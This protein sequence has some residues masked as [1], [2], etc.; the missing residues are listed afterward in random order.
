VELWWNDDG[1]LKY[2]KKTCPNVTLSTTN[3]TCAGFGL[4]PLP[5]VIAW[6][7]TTSAMAWPQI[8]LN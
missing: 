6:Q 4:N 5:A 1:K 7:L 8:T 2:T 3:P